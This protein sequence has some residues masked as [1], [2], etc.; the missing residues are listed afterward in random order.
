MDHGFAFAGANAHRATEIVSVKALVASLLAE[1]QAMAAW[2]ASRLR[3]RAAIAPR[4]AR[5]EPLR[6][7]TDM[8]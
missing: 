2:P 1:Y 5:T 6:A 8:N 4:A 3:R 7:A